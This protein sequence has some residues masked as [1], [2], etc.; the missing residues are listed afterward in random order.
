MINRIYY[1]L[2]GAALVALA[3]CKGEAGNSPE[4]NANASVP[5]ETKITK[6]SA[7]PIIEYTNTVIDFLNATGESMQ[8]MERT[9]GE[10]ADHLKEAD[11]KKDFS[12]IRP[13]TIVDVGTAF[14]KK[15]MLGSF[16]SNL[17]AADRA[18]FADNIKVMD[19]AI[20]ATRAKLKSYDAYLKNQDFKDD[21]GGKAHELLNG[22]DEQNQA[23]HASSEILGAKIR[24]ISDEAEIIA[25]EGHPLREHIIAMKADMKASLGLLKILASKELATNDPTSGATV[26]GNFTPISAVAKA[27]YSK[28]EAAWKEHASINPAALKDAGETDHYKEFYDKMEEFIGS[29]RKN[30]RFG[31]EK[32]Y[33]LEDYIQELNRDRENMISAYNAFAG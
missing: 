8:R 7:G 6:D 23:F 31:E 18:I 5:T 25:L 26:K 2:V 4:S 32:D 29:A 20:E 1:S 27:E 17:S 19:D 16:P 3:G 28:L 30:I 14:P 12:W 11:D 9:A 13:S 33:L 21:K 24:E 10:L 15:S 22:I